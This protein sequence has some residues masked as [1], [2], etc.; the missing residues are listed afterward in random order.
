MW[1]SQFRKPKEK[2]MNKTNLACATPQLDVFRRLFHGT[3]VGS[4]GRMAALGSNLS[5][6][7]SQIRAYHQNHLVLACKKDYSELFISLLVLLTSIAL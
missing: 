1:K 6:G 7:H 3:L 5:L 2:K 4:E